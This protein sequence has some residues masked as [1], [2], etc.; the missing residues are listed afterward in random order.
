MNASIVEFLNFDTND[1]E[2]SGIYPDNFSQILL[3]ANDS[4][5]EG[6]RRYTHTLGVRI[7]LL[8]GNIGVSGFW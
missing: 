4:G 5:N 6:N 3:N 1:E 8:A 2:D 7:F